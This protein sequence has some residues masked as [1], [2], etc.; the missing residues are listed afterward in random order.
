MNVQLA[1]IKKQNL[2]EKYGGHD[3]WNKFILSLFN[4]ILKNDHLSAMFKNSRLENFEMIVSGMFKIF[5]GNVSLEFRRKVRTVHQN[6]G[7]TNI[8]FNNYSNAFEA[9]LHEF[10]VEEDEKCVI[11]SQI[12][13]MKG[14][15]CK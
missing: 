14:L 4:K 12:R 5:D 2:V 11:M 13:S 6:L 3:F 1:K 9:T 7:I 15:I 10:N 8:H